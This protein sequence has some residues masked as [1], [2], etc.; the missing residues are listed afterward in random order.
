[1]I[2]LETAARRPRRN[3]A[4]PRQAENKFIIS[5][6]C[7]VRIRSS[8]SSR[9]AV[10]WPDSF[11]ISSFCVIHISST[12]KPISGIISTRQLQGLAP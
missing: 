2:L 10:L 3:D 1:M 11:R 8:S 9:A 12:M 6:I 7:D 4:S 5:K